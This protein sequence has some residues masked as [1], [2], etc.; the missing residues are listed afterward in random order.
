MR[1]SKHAYTGS[2][3]QIMALFVVLLVFVAF[4]SGIIGYKIGHYKGT[5]KASVVAMNNDGT[6]LTTDDIKAIRLENEINKT[7]V[8]T[9]IQE[10][11]IS[12]NNLNLLR[13]ELQ[14]IKAR[15]GEL[16]QLN[17][18]LM[19]AAIQEGGM[20]LKVLSADMKPLNDGAYE[21]RFE[22]AMLSADGK[23]KTLIPK[24]TLLNSTSMV[25]IPLKPSSYD[26]KG[27]AVINGRF[28][29]PDNFKPSQIKLKLTIDGKHLEQLYDWAV[30][31]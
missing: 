9:L 16:E 27:I 17:A 24:L 20:P 25:D 12:L 2:A 14:D 11:D 13:E 26:L 30:S 3:K 1:T 22:V 19:R 28:I 6:S 18:V 8:S 10:R 29:M 4:V 7:E 31:R 5:H 23:G 15:Q 21:Y